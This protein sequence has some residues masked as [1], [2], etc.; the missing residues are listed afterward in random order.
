MKTV[1]EVIF[2]FTGKVKDGKGISHCQS[3]TLLENMR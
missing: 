3:I 1:K 2:M